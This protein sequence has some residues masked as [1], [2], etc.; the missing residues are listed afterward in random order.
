MPMMSRSARGAA[1]CLALALLPTLVAAQQSDAEWLRNCTERD[2]GGRLARHC[3]VRV[4]QVAAPGGPIRVDAGENGAVA[5]EGWTG[6]GVEIHARV[7]ARALTEAEARGLADAVGVAT[8]GNITATGPENDR[9]A[10]WHVSFLVY[11]PS[12]ADLEVSTNNGP[13]SVRGVTSRMTLETGNGPLALRDVGGDVHA[14]A[15][16]GPL[17][18]S[19]TGDA[20]QGAGLDAET[21]NG[22]V[23]LSVPEGFNAQLETGTQNGPFSSDIPLTVTLQGRLRRGPIALTLG[24]GG[25]PVRVVTTNGPM[26]IRRSGAGAP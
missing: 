11:V 17:S 8:S 4:L 9:D 5:I 24:G 23:T 14:R 10:S 22:P 19:L 3:D 6:S 15:Q 18:V 26:V 2:D 1:A 21:R 13:L 25:P 16:N 7:E 12:S 20:W